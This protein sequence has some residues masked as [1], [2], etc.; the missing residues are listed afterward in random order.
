MEAAVALAKLETLMVVVMVEMVHQ[1]IILKEI[2][3]REQVVEVAV[4]IIE[5]LL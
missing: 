2:L 1:L 4:E 5:P 3:Q